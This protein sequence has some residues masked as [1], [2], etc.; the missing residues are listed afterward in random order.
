MLYVLELNLLCNEGANSTEGLLTRFGGV[1]NF[2]LRLS[3][4]E[5]GPY[6]AHDNLLDVLPHCQV[7]LYI[8]SFFHPSSRP[9]LPKCW[10]WVACA[11]ASNK[12]ITTEVVVVLFF[13][14]G[15]HLI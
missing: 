3:E 11:G 2:D 10:H 7:V 1:I 15:L 14:H 6:G 4:A 12:S 9:S 13:T 5:A 8:K